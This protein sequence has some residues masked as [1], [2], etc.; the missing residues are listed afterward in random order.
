MN[1]YLIKDLISEISMGPF[2][3]NIKVECFVDDGIPV[4][5]GSNLEGF[6]LKEES[7]RYVTEQKAD[8][9]GKAN[10]HRGDVVITH[11]GTLGQIVFIPQNSKFDRYVISQ[12]QFRVK[13]N[14][15]V[16]P[17]YLVYYFHTKLGQHKLL[18]NASQVGVPALAR[19]STTFQMIDIDIPS[20]DIQKKIVDVLET[21]REKIELNNKIN[22]NLLEQAKALFKNWFIDYEPFSANNTMPE[23]WRMGTVGE[24]IEL[25]DSKRIPLSGSERDKMEKIYPYYGATSLMDY[26]DN[27]LFDGIYLLLGEDGTVVDDKG[28]PILQYI[29]G[30][31]WVNNHAHILTGKLGYSVEELYLLFSLTNIKS[32]VTGAVQQKVSQANL[33]KVPA[34]I[35]PVEVLSQ[36]D[37]IIQPIFAEIRNL[38]SENQRLSSIRDSV[39]PKLISGDIDVSEID[40]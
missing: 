23:T 3:S 30:K 31:F 15:K 27:Y 38:R 13:C 20:V 19:A 18:S 10:A 7:F 21:I 2:G 22:N 29:D 11:R 1:N 17:E 6:S 5:N 26:V 28:F 4:L 39:L 24:I 9:L 32:I 8:S 33:K 35:P 37:D 36:F 16:L 14:E 34:I 25:H 12:S 40:I